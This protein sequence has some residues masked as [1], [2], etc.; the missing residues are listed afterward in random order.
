VPAE[1]VRTEPYDVPQ[2]VD[3][4]NRLLLEVWGMV[5]PMADALTVDTWEEPLG[6]VPA[7]K[8]GAVLDVGPVRDKSTL[9]TAAL[10]GQ[11]SREPR[12]VVLKTLQQDWSSD[13]YVQFSVTGRD[14]W[15]G[16]FET[17]EWLS[18]RLPVWACDAAFH[19]LTECLENLGW[20]PEASEQEVRSEPLAPGEIE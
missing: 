3:Y 10:A 1:Y 5:N 18:L 7:P 6:Q 12:S 2:V 17:Q 16:E 19:A 20:L 11:L 9:N 14:E 8:D 15:S 13:A 4:L